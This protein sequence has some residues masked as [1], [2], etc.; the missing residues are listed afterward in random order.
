MKLIDIN[1]LPQKERKRNA[2][3]YSMMGTAALFILILMFMTLSWQST[4]K[5][6]KRTDE[7][8]EM[9]KKVIEAQ[10]TK[11]LGAEASNSVGK[12]SKTVQ[13]MIDYPV[14]TV[15][16]LNKLISL[17]P[18]RGFIQQFEYVDRDLINLTVQ[19]DSSRE[20]AYYLS[21]LKEEKWLL[22]CDILEITTEQ[23]DDSAEEDVL[24]RYLASYSL[25]LD[26]EKFQELLEEEGGEG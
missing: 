1:L 23:L 9:T 8:I 22:K 15:P 19:F 20:A 12:L 2:F 16:I 25:H 24:P 14:K 3:T 21:H 4:V 17:L 18:Q 10:Q 6:T 7:R 13:E 11:V 26:P 5:E